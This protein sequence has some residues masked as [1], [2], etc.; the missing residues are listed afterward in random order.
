MIFQYLVLFIIMV[1]FKECLF[2]YFNGFN[3]FFCRNTVDI[4]VDIEDIG[5]NFKVKVGKLQ[6]QDRSI[7]SDLRMEAEFS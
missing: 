7:K 2:I 5:I 1:Y 4:V 3:V 6:L